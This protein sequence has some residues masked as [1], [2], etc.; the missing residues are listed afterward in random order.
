M[1]RSF[2]LGLG[3]GA[4]YMYFGDR[5]RGEARRQVLIDTATNLR[6][7]AQ[8][9]SRWANDTLRGMRVQV[10]VPSEEGPIQV[11]RQPVETT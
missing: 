11:K 1:I 9:L 5:E 7:D 3:I 4:S 10:S 6:A 8:D 2:L